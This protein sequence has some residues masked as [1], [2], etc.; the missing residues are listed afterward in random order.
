MEE[1]EQSVIQQSL[2][3]RKTSYYISDT[4]S[5]MLISFVVY[6]VP[7]KDNALE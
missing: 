5:C 2:A 7:I 1:F 3:F 4:S 6:S